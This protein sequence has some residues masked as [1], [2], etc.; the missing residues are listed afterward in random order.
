VHLGEQAVEIGHGAEGREDGAVVADVVAVVVVG[1]LVDRADPDHIH[2]QP[3]EMV[4]PGQDAGQV[5]DPIAVGVHEAARVDLVGDGG[6]PPWG[7]VG[8]FGVGAASARG[9]CC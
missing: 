3:L 4:E 2:A 7:A 9:N 1:R 6:L 8:G 5:P